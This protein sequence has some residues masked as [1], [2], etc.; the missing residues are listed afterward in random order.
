MEDR[1]RAM[2][3]APRMWG[4]LE[5]VEMQALQLFEL[6]ALML[7]PELIHDPRRVLDTYLAFL[8]QHFP[9]QPS[10][11]LFGLVE[12]QEQSESSFVQ[13]L[14]Q[15]NQLISK[16]I[17]A[18]NPFEH[19]E[20]AIK[21]T[22]EAGRE[23]AT[24]AFTGYYEEFRRAARAMTRTDK[25]TG[26]VT[27]EIEAAT[28]FSL[29]DAVVT[30]L[31]GVNASV[32]LRLGMARGQ[33][34]WEAEQRVRDGLSDILALSEW[35]GEGAGLAEV[36]VDDPEQRTKAALQ[37]RRLLPRRGIESV[38]I[39][40]KLVARSKPIQLRAAFEARFMEIVGA[41]TEAEDFDERDQVHTIDLDRS[42]ILL[43]ERRRLPC[44]MR[45]EQLGDITEV[46][47][48]A[49]VRGWQYRP[50]MTNAFVL[51]DSVE[52]EDRVG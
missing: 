26:R 3:S 33:A 9:G 16:S 32:L 27:K 24:S 37:A 39:G 29:V 6:R 28:D 8:R 2:L 12:G 21:L 50:L 45:P 10:L 52:L 1:I 41:E 51:V 48:Q 49:R 40:G 4:S 20:L 17:R 47:V 31:N 15:F 43:G 22:F 14:E 7:R 13:T 18:K 11:P 30:Q 5:A 42:V 46:G 34:N 38:E 44:F 35:A 36:P 19:S 23:P 25:S